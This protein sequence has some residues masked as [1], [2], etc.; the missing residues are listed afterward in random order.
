VSYFI[1]FTFSL[2]STISLA[3]ENAEDLD[4]F[5]WSN[6]IILINTFSSSAEYIS[7]LQSAN[8]EITDR[9]ILWF[10]FSDTEMES[11]YQGSVGPVLRENMLENYLPA[12][13][14]RV[15]LIGKDGGIKS[16]NATLD[17][18]DLFAQ[19]DVMPMRRAE[20]REA[21]Q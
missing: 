11:N 7:Q 2:L 10:L 3:Q 4:S 1:C 20:I 14:E 18:L 9:D 19:I 15:I 5:L 8:T 12:N 17:L 21:S 6:R 13:T 16:S